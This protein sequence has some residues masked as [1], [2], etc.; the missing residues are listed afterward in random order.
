MA[1]GRELVERHEFEEARQV[2]QKLRASCA[3][4][5]TK[6]AH[7]AWG[8]AV[9][10]D[11]VGDYEAA[12]EYVREAIELDPLAIPYQRSYEVIVDRIRKA[13]ADESLAAG[14]PVVPRLYQLLMRAGEGDVASHLAMAR[15]H[16]HTGDHA[17]AMKLL[18][19]LTTLAPASQEAWAYK[20]NVARALGDLSAASRAD[21]EAAAL[22]IDA[23]YLFNQQVKALG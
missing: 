18:D 15:H 21:I 23:A 11:G 8:L 20:A 13:L 17:A 22:A 6:S 10:C 1:R 2:Y 4:Q 12:M 7:L 3:R 14:D 19:A 9:A 16:M 5:G